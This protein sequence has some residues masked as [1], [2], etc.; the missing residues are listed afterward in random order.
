MFVNVRGWPKGVKKSQR[1][2]Y[3]H[4][5]LPMYIKY[6]NIKTKSESDCV[7]ILNSSFFLHLHILENSFYYSCFTLHTHKKSLWNWLYT[8]AFSQ[9]FS[10]KKNITRMPMCRQ[11]VTELEVSLNW[12]KFNKQFWKMHIYFHPVIQPHS[13]NVFFC[14]PSLSY[15]M[16]KFYNLVRHSLAQTRLHRVFK[17]FLTD[18]V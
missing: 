9:L 18:P 3:V 4:E 8:V 15:S 7:L 2:F 5:L 13:F 17:T 14:N 1:N 11:S 16:S 6:K 10:S 12:M